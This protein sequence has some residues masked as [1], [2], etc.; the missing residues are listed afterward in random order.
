MGYKQLKAHGE[1]QTLS[2]MF[3]NQTSLLLYQK[4]S[5]SDEKLSS[6]R[7]LK[8]E[9]WFIQ[10]RKRA[11]RRVNI[12]VLMRDKYISRGSSVL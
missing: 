12:E 8:L 7:T 9:N 2:L 1:R 4:I 6:F 5:G 10:K 11:L 3:V